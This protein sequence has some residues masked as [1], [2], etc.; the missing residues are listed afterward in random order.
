MGFLDTKREPLGRQTS[1]LDKS[2]EDIE[3]SR[4]EEI[5]NNIRKSLLCV[6]D[7][8]HTKAVMDHRK[9]IKQPLTELAAER[10]AKQLGKWHDPNEAADEMMLRGWRGFEP[11]WMASKGNGRGPGPPYREDAHMK[12]IRKRFRDID[13]RERRE[14]DDLTSTHQKPRSDPT[15]KR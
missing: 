10:L 12:A 4:E 14:H 6:L 13:E 11:G 9:R 5:I 3:E 2:R 1:V 7:A 8:K 15:P